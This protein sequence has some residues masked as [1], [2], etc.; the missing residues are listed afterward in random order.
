MFSSSGSTEIGAAIT[1]QTAISHLG[2]MCPIMQRKTPRD[3]DCGNYVSKSQVINLSERD[4]TA[5]CVNRSETEAVRVHTAVSGTVVIPVNS[6]RGSHETGRK[7]M[8]SCR[9]G[10]NQ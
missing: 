9:R 3:V 8:M 5:E 7:G 2:I 6:R 1:G 4:S 10:L